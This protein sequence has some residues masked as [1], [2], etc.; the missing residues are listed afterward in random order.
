VALAIDADLLL[1]ILEVAF[2]LGMV[3]FVHE[4][5]HF[6]VAKWCG[7]KC[8]KFYLGFDIYGLK[9]ARF[10]WGETEYGIG[11]LPLG[12]YVKMLGQDDNP[13]R[14]AAERERSEIK[15]EGEEAGG[16]ESAK[17]DPRSYLAKSVPQRMAIISAGV[18]MNVI[19]AFVCAVAAYEL[20][21]PETACGVSAVMPGETAWRADLQPG[22]QVLAIDGREG[23]L[24]FRDLMSSVALGNLDEGVEFVIRREGTDEPIHVNL[25]PQNADGRLLPT[26]GVTSPLSTTLERKPV[27][28]GGT[29]AAETGKFRE[30]DTIVAIDGASVK[31]YA[32]VLSE[33]NRKNDKPVTVTIERKGDAPDAAPTRFDV[34]VEPQPRRTLGIAM[35]MGPIVAI[36]HGSPAEAAGLRRGDVIESIDEKPPGDPLKLPELLR[37]RAGETIKVV[38]AREDAAGKKETLTKEITLRDRQWPEESVMKANPVAVPALGLAYDVL[39]RVQEIDADGPAAKAAATKDGKPAAALTAGDVVVSAEFT[40][41]ELSEEELAKRENDKTQFWVTDIPSQMRVVDLAEKHNWPYLVTALQQLPVGTKVTLTTKDGRSV[42]VFSA[43]AKD[44]YYFDRGFRYGPETV[45]IRAETFNEALSLGG[46]ETLDSLLLVYKFLRR[47]GSQVSPFALGGPITIASAAGSAASEG[48][49][50]LLLF[51][52]LLSANLAV[53]NFLP[54]PLLDGG[55]MVFLALEGIMRRP[56]SEKVVLAFHYAGFVF[57]ISLMLFFICLEFRCVLV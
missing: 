7:V 43:P 10:Q 20:G 44:W 30:G 26:I 53:I 48:F 4:L 21:V 13:S 50:S 47:I 18:V 16:G 32:E 27:V 2:A 29:P 9:L 52:T 31:S 57:I 55:H 38:V 23:N 11:I 35:T 24:R 25:K 51:L 42:E 6:V 45:I 41:P 28:V 39:A 56:V 17:L 12:G 40:L 19:F 3:I 34:V 37:R 49:S 5:G 8:E 15:T 33:L 36:Q 46:A 22:D 54:I 14:Q 1:V